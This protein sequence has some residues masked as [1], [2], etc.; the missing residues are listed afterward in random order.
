MLFW[1]K[2]RMFINSKPAGWTKWQLAERRGNQWY[3]MGWD[4]GT[5]RRMDDKTVVAELVDPDGKPY[6]RRDI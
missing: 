3:F 1:V 5:D 2:Q 6:G 4:C